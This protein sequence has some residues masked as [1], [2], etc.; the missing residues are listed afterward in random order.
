[1]K[2]NKYIEFKER[3]QA[4]TNA[5]PIHFAFGDRQLQEKAEKLGFK[6]VDE[7]IKNVTGI[8]AGGFVLKNDLDLVLDTFK[9]HD[10]EMKEALKD[11]EFLESA[12][13]YELGNHEYIITYDVGDALRAL[14]ITYKEYQENERY[15]NIM[16]KA[17]KNYMDYIE[18]CGW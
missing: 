3:Q 7:M 4:E 18:K 11:D 8:G 6:T 2:N 15:K 12:F 14:G 17:I 13:E 1:M 9:R 16:K 5:L 10:E